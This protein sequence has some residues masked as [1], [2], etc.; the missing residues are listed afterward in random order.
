VKQK[1]HTK[2]PGH[3]LKQS[4]A[5]ERKF[6]QRLTDILSAAAEVIAERGFEGASVREVASRGGIGLSGIYY[7]FKSKDEMLFA[8]QRNTFSALSAGLHE[9]LINV[10]EPQRRLR[11][12]VENHLGYF[13]SHPQELK[14]CFH[15]LDS[16]R[17]EYYQRVLELRREY[18]DIVRGVMAEL[19]NNDEH[20]VSLNTLFLFGSLNWT[21]MWYDPQEGDDSRRVIDTLVSLY[22][23]GACGRCEDKNMQ[24]MER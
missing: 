2:T 16:L 22:T 12:V 11:A 4:S 14:V 10:N 3:L 24:S 1:S 9:R 6:R 18:Y 13:F 7:Y 15:E 5:Q 21:H 20:T 19:G 8:I 23:H 17:G